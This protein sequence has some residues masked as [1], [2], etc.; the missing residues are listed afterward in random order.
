ML[1]IVIACFI[2]HLKQ[3]CRIAP[4]L[5]YLIQFY[6]VDVNVNVMVMVIV[7]NYNYLFDLP[8]LC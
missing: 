8:P 4:N 3:I 2:A 6:D 7:L 1:L 5:V